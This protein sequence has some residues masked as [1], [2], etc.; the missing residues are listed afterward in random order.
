MNLSSLN[1]ET[2]KKG[3]FQSSP[4]DGRPKPMT[5]KFRAPDSEA[6]SFWGSAGKTIELLSDADTD[7]GFKEDLALISSISV[8]QQPKLLAMLFSAVDTEDIVVVVDDNIPLS[9]LLFL[10]DD[11]VVVVD[12]D[13]SHQF[14]LPS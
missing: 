14:P 4:W 13:D 2:Y 6:W 12:D 11:V 10:D 3:W 9:N 8:G 1:Q 5:C 7:T